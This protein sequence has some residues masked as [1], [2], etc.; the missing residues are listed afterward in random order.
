MKYS[1]FLSCFLLVSFFCNAQNTPVEFI[2][3]KGQWNGPFEYKAMTGRGD[4]YLSKNAFSYILSDPENDGKMDAWHHG[5]VTTPQILKFHAYRMFF[6]GANTP[7]ITPG[8]VEE[9]YYNYF[10]GKDSS[11]WKGNIHPCL[12]VDYAQL[13]NGI[14]MHVSSEKGNIK[15]EF[16]V[17]AGADPAQ[18]QLRYDGPSSMKLKNGNLNISTSVGE[19]LEMKPYVYQY[20]NNN[21][22]LVSCDYTLHNNTVSFDFPDGYDKH[23]PLI[24]DPTVVFATFTGSTAD[25][26]GFTATYDEH[27]NFYAG[28]LAN[29]TGY[30]VS[31]GAFQ[32]TFAGGT[33]SDAIE[34][35][36][37]I[38]I[39]KYTPDGKNRIWATYVGGKDNERPHSMIVDSADNLCFTGRTYSNDYPVTSGAYSTSFKGG[40]A[41]I[42]VTKLSADGSS[43]IGSTFMGGSADDGVNYDSTETGYG[44]LKHNY[45]DDARGEIQVDR[46]QNVYVTA[47]TNS[48]DFPVTSGAYKTTNSGGQDA[49][50]FKMNPNLTSLIYSTYIGGSNDDAGYVLAFDPGQQNIYVAGGTQSSNFPSTSGTLHTSYQGGSADGFVMKF[51]NSTPYSLV[52]SSFIGTTDYDQTYGIQVDAAN[53]VYLMGQSLGGLYPVTSGTYNNPNS[54]QFIQKLDSTLS[55]SLMSTVFGNG[56]PTHTNISPV[57]FL[58]DTCGNIYIS[59]WG[60]DLFIASMPS[61]VGMDTAMPITIDAAQS[62]TDGRDFYFICLSRNAGSLLYGTYMGENGG[63]GE[64]VDGGTSRFDKN[65]IV[66]QAICGGCGHSSAFPTTAG[67]WSRTNKSGN[68]NEIALKIAFELTNVVAK[69]KASPNAQ[70][71][72]PFHVNFLDSSI[73]AKGYSWNFGD[74]G[75]DTARY[76]SHTFTAA[77]VY[78]VRLITANPDACKTLDTAYLTITVDT[79]FEH[80][81]FTYTVLD[82]CN[83]YTVSFNNNSVFSSTPGSSTFTKFTWLFGDGTSYSGNTPPVHNYSGIGTYT[84]SLVMVDTTACN[85]PDTLKLPVRINSLLVKAGFNVPDSICLGSPVTLTDSSANGTSYTWDFG[86]GNSSTSASTTHIYDSVGTYT[87]KHV[88]RNPNSCNGVDSVQKTVVV[89]TGPTADFTFSPLTPITNVPT[90]F[91][92]ESVNAT[93]YLWDFGDGAN[94][95]DVNPSHFYKRTGTYKVCLQAKNNTSCPA[96]ACKMVSADVQPLADLP[97][98]FSP[99]GDG[100]NDILFVRGAAIQ[101]MDVKIFNRW[102]QKVF[103]TTDMNEGWDG[104][105]NGQPQ[106]IDA[107]AFIL[108]V[109]FIDGT[110]YEKKGNVTLLR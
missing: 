44:N 12:N 97:T 1:Y 60:G 72:A 52:A 103:E 2:A 26:W 16:I 17:A 6:Q 30:P 51:K 94:S 35:A 21:R 32:T 7:V 101:T 31:T 58:V 10:L 104:N 53:H 107:Y 55:T 108:N 96:S 27:G 77:G 79:I 43:L 54:T 65:G 37:D 23:Q 8:K 19:V 80:P 62:T 28:G 85:S 100:K 102:G 24:I 59:G 11:R 78:K 50:L 73:N 15:Y 3:N 57:A 63:V 49:V 69:A 18:I 4:V 88:V 109:T 71:C 76:P 93:K 45:G 39:I 34:F 42:I 66:Y 5:Q 64:H 20:I 90:S 83:P 92:N 74:G 91:T 48:T 86:D 98:G 61:T 33:G 29:G 106:P 22:E 9:G 105:F 87:I 13:Y 70:G 82:S 47:C 81:A 25:N 68:C 89:V 46:A 84:V 99:N 36:S 75:T 40:R 14:D 110:T 95:T 67:V 56:D 41:D 38:A